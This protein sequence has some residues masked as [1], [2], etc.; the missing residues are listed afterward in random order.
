MTIYADKDHE[1]MRCNYCGTKLMDMESKNLTYHSKPDAYECDLCAATP[2]A[3]PLPRV[4]VLLL[5]DPPHL[6]TARLLSQHITLEEAAYQLESLTT[7]RTRQEWAQIARS[8]MDEPCNR[9][10]PTVFIHAHLS[11][12]RV[13]IDAPNGTV[14]A[15]CY[16]LAEKSC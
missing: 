14:A 1:N 2:A 8:L 6:D 16:F 12:A 3:A 7:D 10:K 9:K 13:M 4:K 11:G 15:I 5:P